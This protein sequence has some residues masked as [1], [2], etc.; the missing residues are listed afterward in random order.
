MEW[1]IGISVATYFM[2]GIGVDKMY[3]DSVNESSSAILV[4]VW[5]LFLLIIALKG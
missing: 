2:L 5:P 1:I 3:Q 4:L